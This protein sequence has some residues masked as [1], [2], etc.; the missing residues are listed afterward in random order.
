MYKAIPHKFFKRE[1]KKYK[2]CCININLAVN[3]L[4]LNKCCICNLLY[5]TITLYQNDTL[6]NI[7]HA[8]S[9]STVLECKL[10]NCLVSYLKPCSYFIISYF[11]IY[12]I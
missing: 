3:P 5:M 12:H 11:I 4:N 6:C 1:V 2:M 8:Q 10:V 9:P 7:V